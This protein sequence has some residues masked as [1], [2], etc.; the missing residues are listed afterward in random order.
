MKPVEPEFRREEARRRRRSTGHQRLAVAVA[1]VVVVILVI[2][3]AVGLSGRGDGTSSTTA[4]SETTTSVGTG[5]TSTSTPEGNSSSTTG[6]GSSQSTTTSTGAQPSGARTFTAKLSG[7]NEVPRVTT[8]ATGTL[9]LT[10]SSNGSSVTFV[11]KVTNIRNLTVARLHQGAQGKNGSTIVTLYA[12]PTK[13]GT[14]TGTVAQGSFT[15]ANLVGPLK[16]KTITDLVALLK[17]GTVYLNVGTTSHASGEIRG[18]L[19]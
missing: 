7:Q 1:L 12:G 5:S 3:L 18:Q 17:A 15:K 8:S 6:T 9:T 14:F 2:V 4:G 16:G 19:Q 13:S 10:V 11:L